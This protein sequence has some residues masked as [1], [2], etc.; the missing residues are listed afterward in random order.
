MLPVQDESRD[1]TGPGC[2]ANGEA[3]G[4]DKAV[5]AV[6][7]GSWRKPWLELE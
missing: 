6:A 2:N 5:N 3:E 4:T 7:E 1:D